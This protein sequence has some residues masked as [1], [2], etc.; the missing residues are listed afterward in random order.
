MKCLLL[1][2]NSERRQ[3][4]PLLEW[5][6]SKGIFKRSCLNQTF[7]YVN[8]TFRKY[9]KKMINVHLNA[10][11]TKWTHPCS[12]SRTI[13]KTL[14]VPHCSPSKKWPLLQASFLSMLWWTLMKTEL[15]IISLEN[16][17]GFYGRINKSK[18]YNQDCAVIWAVFL[19]WLLSKR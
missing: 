15:L 5:I 1:N 8:N 14:S 6:V 19:N 12:P 4:W 16:K 2:G 7:F 18:I 11:I 13:N 17:I 9:T 3:K 10:I